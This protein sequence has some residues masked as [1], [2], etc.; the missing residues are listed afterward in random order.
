VE[1]FVRCGRNQGVQCCFD[2]SRK[3]FSVY[4][5]LVRRSA[6]KTGGFR[7]KSQPKLPA[8]NEALVN[9]T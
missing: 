8:P 7:G 5:V 1:I 2:G 3:V 6:V 9:I 4:F